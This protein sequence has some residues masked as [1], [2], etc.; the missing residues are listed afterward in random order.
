MSEIS[1]SQTAPPAFREVW[2]DY[3][4]FVRRPAVPQSQFPFGATA[5]RVTIAL[6]ALDVAVMLLLAVVALL[7][8]SL[9]VTWLVARQRRLAE[10][11]ALTAR[12]VAELL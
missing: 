9:G 8:V 5:S 7:A 4:R 6:F 10:R 3:V 2:R 12:R 11:E 1:T